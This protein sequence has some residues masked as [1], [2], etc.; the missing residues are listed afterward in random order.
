MLERLVRAGMDCARLNFSHGTPEE[1]IRTIKDIRRI[2]HS[3]GEQIA[4]M[5]DLPGPKI[6]VGTI[7]GGSV[8]L[9]RG[10]RVLL[11]TE[12]VPGDETTIPVRHE[13]LPRY[14]AIGAKI[15]LS[16][17]F[18]RLRVTN[19]TDSV[20]ECICEVGGTLTSGKG[21][22]VPDLSEDFET[23]TDKDRQYLQIGLENDI[24]FV[25]VSYV[26]SA[27]D[28]KLVKDF[29]ESRKSNVSIIAKIEKRAGVENLEQI[30]KFADA[31][32]VARGDLGVENPIE[33]I[34]ELQK[35]IISRCNHAARPVI[36]A[37]QMLESM[38]NNPS[39]T[40]AEVTDIANSIFDGTDAVMLS[41]ETTVGKYPLQCVRVL[42][43]VALNAESEMKNYFVRQ[44]RGSD[45]ADLESA[46]CRAATSIAHTIGAKAI[47]AL[48][49]SVATK[50]SRDRPSMPV[51][52]VS[53]HEDALRKLKLTWGVIGVR[54]KPGETGGAGILPAS[55]L[56]R[57]LV[58]E[59]DEVVWLSDSATGRGISSMAI[60]VARAT[61][62]N[63]R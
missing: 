11:T 61:G 55:I 31:V 44:N 3:L 48:R 5:Q 12:D 37:T 53:K 33:Q 8:S 20:I 23:F 54:A 22:N 51:L 30:I 47:V 25:A 24:D 35:S 45:S 28:V 40:R 6:R 7:S 13:T 42:H 27:R 29:L 50:L 41:E 63:A 43:T 60:V 46:M 49:Q 26:R 36:T 17:G 9:K 10:S 1:H 14:V 16:D 34:P 58:A 18:I 32:M 56:E 38:V 39:P 15:F 57:G 59:N 62:K 52:A 19:K 4:V 21:V 2:S